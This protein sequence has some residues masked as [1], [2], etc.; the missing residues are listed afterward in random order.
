MDSVESLHLSSP[1]YR[2][3]KF[4][5]RSTPSEDF[6][7]VLRSDGSIAL[8][9]SPFISMLALGRQS[10]AKSPGAVTL[11]SCVKRSMVVRLCMLLL[12]LCVPPVGSNLASC[13]RPSSPARSST[14]Y[15]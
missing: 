14:G 11:G 1:T 9:Y 3:M 13:I 7:D 8:C 4:E 10:S 12:C 5:E 15:Q 6:S 2:I